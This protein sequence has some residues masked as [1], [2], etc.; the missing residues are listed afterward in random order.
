MDIECQNDNRYPDG[1]V[2][3]ESFII[4]NHPE[5][6]HCTPGSWKIRYPNRLI[7]LV[8]PP[9]TLVITERFVV[10]ALVIVLVLDTVGDSD[11]LEAT[12]LVY[13]IVLLVFVAMLKAVLVAIVRPQPLVTDT[14]NDR[15]EV[16]ALVIVIV[17]L[18]VVDN[19]RLVAIA[20]T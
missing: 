11:M 20:L 9:E 15:L 7:N 3:P 8:S 17:L 1:N 13:A 10:I 5:L 4:P 18:T 2:H 14:A 16:V 19:D 12:A 6:L